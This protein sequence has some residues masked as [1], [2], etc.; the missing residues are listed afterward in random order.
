MEQV[1]LCAVWPTE[2]WLGTSK[3]TYK[4]GWMIWI[5][6]SRALDR[7]CLRAR[8]LKRNQSEMRANNYTRHSFVIQTSKSL[9]R[10]LCYLGICWIFQWTTGTLRSKGTCQNAPLVSIIWQDETMFVELSYRGQWRQCHGLLLFTCREISNCNL[11]INSTLEINLSI[12]WSFPFKP[13][14]NTKLYE[15]T[16]PRLRDPTSWPRGASSRN[17]GPI[18]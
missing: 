17:Q 4:V 15:T 6:Y 7:W 14:T 2:N 9:T 3:T 16:S 11:D 18:L 8:C 5:C 13:I 12:W 1:R 10:D